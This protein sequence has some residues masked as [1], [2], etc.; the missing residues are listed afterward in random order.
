M[1]RGVELL[2]TSVGHFKSMPPK[3]KK[4]RANPSRLQAFHAAIEAGDVDGMEALLKDEPLLVNAPL[5]GVPPLVKC[6][7]GPIPERSM[8]LLRLHGMTSSIVSELL[9]EA[10]R[11]GAALPTVDYVIDWLRHLDGRDWSQRCGR[12]FL[13]ALTQTIQH[14]HTAVALH[15]IDML[16]P[17]D[18]RSMSPY[19]YEAFVAKNETV[20]LRLLSLPGPTLNLSDDTL[21]GMFETVEW[22][23]RAIEHHWINVVALLDQFDHF[24]PIIFASCYFRP[25]ATRAAIWA[26]SVHRYRS[27]MTWQASRE[28]LL[29]QRRRVGLPDDIGL[30]VAAFLFVFDEYA[31]AIAHWCKTCDRWL[32]A[33]DCELDRDSD[34]SDSDIDTFDPSGSSDESDDWD[35][36]DDVDN[37]DRGE[38]DYG[39]HPDD[40]RKEVDS[41]L[42][43]S[44]DDE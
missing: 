35:G 42:V 20:T 38:D 44:R 43:G 23:V 31:Q 16:D 3:E 37:D 21:L 1:G 9:D 4:R 30:L 11:Q 22:V 12:I 18:E 2:Q 28:A 32:E 8:A 13:R 27:D 41:F 24:R 7:A 33:C 25:L 29:V 39:M 34:P 40:S 14:S 26:K 15:L 6:L 36:S 17:K 19:I 5:Y 10:C